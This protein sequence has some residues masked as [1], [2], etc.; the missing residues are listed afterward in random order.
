MLRKTDALNLEQL[1]AASTCGKLISLAQ[2]SSESLPTD[3]DEKDDIQKLEEAFLHYEQ[4]ENGEISIKDLCQLLFELHAELPKDVIV[5]LIE[6]GDFNQNKRISID[7]LKNMHS[8]Y[9]E[10]N[11]Q[12]EF[13]ESEGKS[14]ESG[15]SASSEE[16]A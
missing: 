14:D 4:D 12:S 13:E 7:D 15:E 5:H 10:W 2:Q 16:S 8:I 3:A 11:D 6:E 1:K 9:L